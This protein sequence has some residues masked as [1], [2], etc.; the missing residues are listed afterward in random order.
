MRHVLLSGPWGLCPLRPDAGEVGGGGF[1]R[2]VLGDKLAGEGLFQDGLAQGIGAGEG[3]VDLGFHL[4]GGVEAG[5]E[6]A[7]DFGLF[8]TIK[9]K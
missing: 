2:G 9:G 5:V 7:G 3:G 8:G 6:D 4:V 1:I